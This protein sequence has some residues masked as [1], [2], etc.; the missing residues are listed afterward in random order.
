MH[1]MAFPGD[2]AGKT[3]GVFESSAA[4]TGLAKRIAAALKIRKRRTSALLIAFK[5]DAEIF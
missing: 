1:T 5:C 3:T 2:G 4:R